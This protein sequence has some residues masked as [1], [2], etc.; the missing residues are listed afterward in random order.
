MHGE[1]F[2]TK[3][4]RTPYL[5]GPAVEL[6]SQPQVYPRALLSFLEGFDETLKFPEY[7]EDDYLGHTTDAEALT[8]IAG[9]L[10]Y[11]SF[12]PERTMNADMAKYIENILRSGH[13]S[14]LEHANFSFLCWGID[15]S[16]SHELV[17]H[18]AGL[19]FSQVSQR[20]V[21]GKVLRFVERKSYQSDTE[22]H[23]MFENR[24]DRA[25]Q[26]YDLLAE[27]LS[28]KLADRPDF[29]KLSKRD[30]RKLVN[31][32][33]RSC[34]PNETEAPIIMTVNA[35]SG[36]HISQMRGTGPADVA[37]SALL[38]K[39]IPILK[40]VGGSLFADFEPVKLDDGRQVWSSKYPKV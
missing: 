37:I 21:D 23:Q 19:A 32:D 40:E 22:L 18:R 4:G 33:A 10:C 28:T 1:V 29:E 8:K 7:C 38:D 17:R 34:L 25:A 6:L 11:M 15:R 26:E 35:R 24:I 30:R 16:V 14:V 13:G 3:H 5:K 9:Q 31:Q 2:Y 39:A 20:Y 12:G 36:R 27:R